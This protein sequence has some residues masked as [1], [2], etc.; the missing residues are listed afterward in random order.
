MTH[1]SGWTGVDPEP[2]CAGSIPGP[3]PPPQEDV[4]ANELHALAQGRQPPILTPDPWFQIPATPFVCLRALLHARRVA[5]ACGRCG[6]T[7]SGR[8]RA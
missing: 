6:T 5:P 2:D 1:L 4:S 7:S 8:R 3:S